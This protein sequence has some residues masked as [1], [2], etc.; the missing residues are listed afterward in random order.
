MSEVDTNE[1]VEVV[2]VAKPRKASVS[3]EKFIGALKAGSLATPKQTAQQIADSLDMAKTS[4]DQRLN[5]YRNDWKAMV[6][7]GE[8]TGPFPFVLAD[9]RSERNGESVK[10]QTSKNAILAALTSVN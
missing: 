5:Q 3:A 10:G 6:E 8:V 9:G 1:V 2:K 4:F 7:A